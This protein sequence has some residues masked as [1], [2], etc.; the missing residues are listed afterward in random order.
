MA[1]INVEELERQLELMRAIA[2]QRIKISDLQEHEKT[3]VARLS[4]LFLAEQRNLNKIAQQREKMAAQYA[5]QG[6]ESS[7]KRQRR[8]ADIAKFVSRKLQDNGAEYKKYAQVAKK[9]D[10]DVKKNASANIKS[11]ATEYG[12]VFS[13]G[14]LAGLGMA[15][16]S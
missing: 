13:G 9:A 5:S 1:D 6:N 14:G 11:I 3:Q 12:A 4:Q 2:E 10:N 8:E 16:F 7:A 15:L